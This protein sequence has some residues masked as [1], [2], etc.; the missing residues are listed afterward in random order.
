MKG[1]ESIISLISFGIVFTIL[2]FIFYPPIYAIHDEAAYM[3]QAYVMQECTIFGDVAGIPVV[4]SIKT[5]TGHLV[6]KYAPGVSFLLIPFTFLGWKSIFLM[7][8]IL[9]IV[10]F[11]IFIKILRIYNISTYF[12]LFYLIY[13]ASVL[14]SRTIMA[15]VHSAVFFI[16]AVYFFLRGRHCYFQNETGIGEGIR[17]VKRKQLGRIIVY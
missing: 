3:A 12:S 10:G 1:K 11:I 16:I 15:D 9:H 5:P 13:P 2:W 8:L 14:Y 4:S 17:K 7:P 6:T